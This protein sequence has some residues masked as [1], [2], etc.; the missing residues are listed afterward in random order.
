MG[1][2]GFLLFFFHIYGFDNISKGLWDFSTE[3]S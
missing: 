1:L 2:T 3:L